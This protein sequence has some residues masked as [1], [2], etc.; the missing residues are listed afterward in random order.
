MSGETLTKRKKG[1][2]KT[3]GNFNSKLSSN[4]DGVTIK[5]ESKGTSGCVKLIFFLLL[6]VFLL[7]STVIY[8]DYKPGTL[9]E[10]YKTNVPEEV[11]KH[12][13]FN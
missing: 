9:Q 1:K 10:A 7:M 3:T 11:I 5:N 2:A 12:N 8:V 6:S 4:S 13:H